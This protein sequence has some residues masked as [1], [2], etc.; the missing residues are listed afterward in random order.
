MRGILLPLY[1]GEGGRPQ[2]LFLAELTALVG[3][4]ESRALEA[5]LR[6]ESPSRPSA[7]DLTAQL[8]K[9]AGARVHSVRVTHIRNNSTQPGGSRTCAERSVPRAAYFA[10]VRIAGDKPDAPPSFID[11]RPSD[12]INLAVRL[13]VPI[14]V[15]E[16]LARARGVRDEAAPAPPAPASPPAPVVPK[17]LDKTL[18]LRMRI[19]VAVAEGRLADGQRLR[20]EVVQLLR[21]DNGLASYGTTSLAEVAAAMMLDLERAV[22]EERY[23]DAAIAQATLAAL[24]E[25]VHGGGSG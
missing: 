8:M 5:H 10:A 2:L 4:A 11:S 7:Y 18:E 24:D 19:A 23:H 15:S 22:K 14:Y 3:D 21:S 25:D 9:A 12:A 6:H 20:N 16:D 1:V 17:R 13:G